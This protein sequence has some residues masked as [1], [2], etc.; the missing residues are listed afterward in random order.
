[1]SSLK[2]LQEPRAVGEL[3][4]AV[5]KRPAPASRRPWPHGTV[6]TADPAL[7]AAES[8]WRSWWQLHQAGK[9][10]EAGQAMA[11]IHR[12]SFRPIDLFA[13][14]GEAR[15]AHEPGLA[16]AIFS[17][18]ELRAAEEEGRERPGAWSAPGPAMEGRRR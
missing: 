3:L 8:V 4:P 17:V 15:R 5:L 2:R 1:M 12:T 6:P 16:D 13:L 14:W 11:R 9:D 7:L 18:L 10:R